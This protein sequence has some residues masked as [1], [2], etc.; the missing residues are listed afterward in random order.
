MVCQ[1]VRSHCTCSDLLIRA[2]IKTGTERK[3]LKMLK[4]EHTCYLNT[5]IR[6]SPYVR[7]MYEPINN[8]SDASNKDPYCLAFEWMDCTLKDVSSAV[9]S[10]NC[11]LYKS[12]AKAVLGGLVD[13]K[14]QHLVHTG[15][16]DYLELLV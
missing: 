12:I 8:P 13:L 11:A 15:T 16:R 10:R 5:T 6:S 2:V 4:H 14:S 9:H 1:Y 7:A 3:E